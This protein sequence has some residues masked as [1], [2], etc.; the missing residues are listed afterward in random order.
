M[1]DDEWLTSQIYAEQWLGIDTDRFW[2]MTVQEWNETIRVGT[3]RHKFFDKHLGR[4]SWIM[5]M[6]G[7]G[8]GKRL[9][10]FMLLGTDQLDDDS[11]FSQIEGAMESHGIPQQTE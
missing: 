1:T 9:D 3:A 10:D 8:K 7:G 4:L 5:F 11:I 2:D 6:A